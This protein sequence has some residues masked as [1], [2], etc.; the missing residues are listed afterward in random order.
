VA[1]AQGRPASFQGGSA[2]VQ[3]VLTELGVD[4]TDARILDGSGLSRRNRLAPETLL[5]VL[6]VAASEDHPELRRAVSGLPVAG[7]TGSLSFRFDSGDDEGRGRVRAKTGTLTGV[8]GL[9]GLVTDEEGTVMSF[10]AIADR[11]KP[12]NTLDARQQ[13]DEVAAALAACS[14]AA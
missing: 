1:I 8:H 12:I 7:F 13:L 10:V 14:C 11:V 9:A 4:T 5:A 3:E 6:E 2:A